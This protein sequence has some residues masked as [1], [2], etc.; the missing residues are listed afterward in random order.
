MSQ[1]EPGLS[2][3]TVPLAFR[4]GSCHV[5]FEDGERQREHYRSDWHRF[6]L[7]RKISSLPPV[8]LSLYEA[9]VAE[10]MPAAPAPRKTNHRKDRRKTSSGTASSSSAAAR[11]AQV[12]SH[13]HSHAQPSDST[14]KPASPA[15]ASEVAA[16]FAS[17]TPSTEPSSSASSSSS[18]SVSSPAFRAPTALD[19]LTGDLAHIGLSEEEKQ[20][21]IAR[22]D[23]ARRKKAREE[24]VIT[25]RDSLFDQHR[26][27]S[28]ESNLSYMNRKYGLFIPNQEYCTDKSGLVGMMAEMV[29]VHHMCLWCSKKFRSAEGT[30]HHMVR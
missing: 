29:Y 16:A 8:A 20:R 7:K 23:A 28:L 3:T 22:S 1:A 17:S 18:S 27:K 13:A 30:Q 5:F 11:R 4:C 25:E 26:S 9:K 12:S 2:V 6:N 24:R 19:Q 15:I 14:L 10:S 21:A